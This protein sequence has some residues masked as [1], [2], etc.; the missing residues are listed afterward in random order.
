M[1]RITGPDIATHVAQ[2][3]A[4]VVRAAIELF[5][6]RGYTEV[7][8]ADIAAAVGLART[9]LYRYFPDKDHI[10]LA[11]L[12]TEIDELVERSQAIAGA[13]LPATTRLVQW[14]H[15]H[16]D[17]IADPDHQLFTAIAATMGNLSAA[18]RAEV[19]DQHRRL[20]AT[21]DG[22][23]ADALTAPAA[24]RPASAALHDRHAGP[25]RHPPADP[26]DPDSPDDRDDRD[27]QIVAALV[28]GMFR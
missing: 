6:A 4:A 25:D 24:G 2:Q 1:P 3:E 23:V 8:L 11:W 16:L 7:T 12:R 10:L 13:D 21:V 26:A 28:L 22:I 17:Y 15:L 19:V 5:A 9:S 18:V 27:P 14:F 20:Y